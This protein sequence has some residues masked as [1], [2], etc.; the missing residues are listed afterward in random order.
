MRSINTSRVMAAT[1][2]CAVAAAAGLSATGAKAD[3]EE[4]TF[5]DPTRIDNPYLPLSKFSRCTLKGHE[6]NQQLRIKRTVLDRTR[7]FTAGAVAFEAMVVKDRVWADG[8]LIERT[9]D[10]FAQD[11][12]GAVRYLGENVDNIRNGHV[13]DHHGGWLYGRD[14]QKIGVLIPGNV[15]VG[16][17]WLSEDAPPITVE[18][19]RVVAEIPKV[20]VRGQTYDHAVKVREF[21]LPD[22]EVEYKVYAKGVGV[23]DEL[24]P[25]GDVGLVGCSR[26]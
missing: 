2:L 17:H 24:P 11:D 1:A 14:T 22:K 5:S 25:E 12:S 16:V 10:F 13:V 23:I 9:I 20:E 4:P 15:H 8:K 6:G 18:H 21:A 26:A 7:T 3:P 19:D